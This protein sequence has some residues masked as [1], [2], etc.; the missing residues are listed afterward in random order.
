M[1]R[2]LATIAM[3]A[4]ITS[5][6]TAVGGTLAVSGQSRLDIPADQ[7]SLTL[8]ATATDTTVDAARADVDATMAKLVAVV[9]DAGLTKHKEWHTDRYDVSPQWKPRPRNA[10]DS[11]KPAI[12]GY[13]VRTNLSITSTKMELAGVLVAK[14][15]KAGAN[16]IGA[17]HFSLADHRASRKQAIEEAARHAIADATS[18]A[19]ASGVGLI[20]ILRLSLDGANASPPQPVEHAYMLGSAMRSMSDKDSAP[21]ISG[22]MVTV[23]ASVTAEWEIAPMNGAQ[24]AQSGSAD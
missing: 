8:G 10:D 24:K 20:Q 12:V 14:A 19:N 11:W 5:V 3:L 1:I 17:L 21:D 15:A 7:F 9:T 13:T 6:A 23:T 4:T 2:L 22:G 18:L 16:S